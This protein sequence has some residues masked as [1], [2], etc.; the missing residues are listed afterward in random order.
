MT[1]KIIEN[2]P[3]ACLSAIFRELSIPQ[4]LLVPH[5]TQ[6]CPTGLT[7]GVWIEKR[8]YLK[9]QW[10]IFPGAGWGADC[11]HQ[12]AKWDKLHSYL[13]RL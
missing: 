9:F 8:A 2:T 6:G 11:F 10:L 4:Q 7:F 13:K 1:K 5:V 3:T 12:L